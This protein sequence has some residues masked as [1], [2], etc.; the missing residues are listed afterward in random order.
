[1]SCEQCGQ[2][3]MQDHLLCDHCLG[4]LIR[5]E[6]DTLKPS[7]TQE[8]C[9]EL[10][11]EAILA[12]IPDY[13][14]KDM[15]EILDCLFHELGT[16]CVVISASVLE[17]V[18]RDYCY[19]SVKEEVPGNFSQVIDR[20]DKA[21]HFYSPFIELLN[22]LRELRNEAMFGERRFSPAEAIATCKQVL[23]I[24]AFIANIT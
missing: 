1:M 3:A 7:R 13:V 24:V 9:Q 19:D 18:V 22:E 4:K 21:G 15:N 14:E 10:Y 12:N 20:L 5:E 11:P 16:A 23:A 8:N 6:I 2:F 17:S